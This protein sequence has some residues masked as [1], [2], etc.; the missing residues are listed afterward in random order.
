M[1]LKLYRQPL[2]DGRVRL[3]SFN[4]QNAYEKKVKRMIVLPIVDYLDKH[5][6]IISIQEAGEPFVDAL[7]RNMG[8]W[9]FVTH[10]SG[11]E[12]ATIGYRRYRTILLDTGLLTHADGAPIQKNELSRPPAYATFLAGN[13]SFYL[14]NPHTDFDYA[15]EEVGNLEG[16]VDEYPEEIKRSMIIAGDLNL[17]TF[18]DLFKGYSIYPH[19]SKYSDTLVSK[20]RSAFDRFIV[21]KDIKIIGNTGKVHREYFHTDQM[22]EMA[23]IVHRRYAEEKFFLDTLATAYSDH[24]PIGL[25]VRFRYPNN[26]LRDNIDKDIMGQ[27]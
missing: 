26:W 20:T 27:R 1:S 23:L 22:K 6:D 7:R 17:D 2:Y 10:E 8:E 14:I 4:I 11:D 5:A 18:G 24:Y 12:V 13:Q 25:H 21:G 3:I 19:D 16:I 15:K 9:E